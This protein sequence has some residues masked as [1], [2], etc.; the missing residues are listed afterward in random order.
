MLPAPGYTNQ[1]MPQNT[2]APSAPMTS[3]AS[4]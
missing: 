1:P 2:P 4:R 3:A